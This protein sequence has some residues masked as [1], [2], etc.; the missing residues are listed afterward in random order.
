MVLALSMAVTALAIDTVLPAFAAI[1]ADL[2]YAADSTAIAGIVT[3]FL[4]GSSAGL[5]PAGLLADRFG[6]RPVLW[7][8]VALYMIGAIGAVLAPSLGVMLVARFVWGLG[9]SGPRVAALAMVRDVYE[10]EQMAR[11]MSFMMAVF[12]VVPAVAPTIGAGLVHVGPWVLVYWLCFAAGAAVLVLSLRLPTTLPPSERQTLAPRDIAAGIK[13][14]LATPGTIAYLVAL[15]ALFAAFISYLASSEIIIAE[16][17]DLASW[18]PL[19]FGA[20]ALVLMGA[21][22]LNG[23]IVERVGLDRLMKRLVVIQ[24]VVDGSLVGLAFAT[25]GHPPFWL[26]MIVFGLAVGSR[27]SLIPNLNSAAMRPLGGVAGTATAILGTVSGVIGSVIGSV[28]DRAFD[29]T[30]TPISI[31]FF[32]CTLVTAAATLWGLAVSPGETARPVG[33]RIVIGPVPHP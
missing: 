2:G 27:Q 19:I 21:M 3:A 31:A 6:R 23:R 18:F 15:T 1:R 4:A 24:L 29:G 11:Q 30:V 28:I 5:L 7:G 16:V 12:L 25:G 17:F 22:L 8:G 10:G 33:D 26:F 13:T 9:S 32:V 14:V 20:L